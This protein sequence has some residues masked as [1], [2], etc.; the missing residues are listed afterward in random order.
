ME[1]NCFKFIVN[2]GITWLIALSDIPEISVRFRN[3]TCLTGKTAW[4]RGWPL[5]DWHSVRVLWC[6]SALRFPRFW[7]FVLVFDIKLSAFRSTFPACFIL[8]HIT[9]QLT[10]CYGPSRYV[11]RCPVPPN[12]PLK[13]QLSCAGPRGTFCMWCKLPFLAS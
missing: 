8:Q 1:Q 3:C 6:C 2:H 9:E 10:Y 12:E 4:G 13:S 5:V 7:F 11:A